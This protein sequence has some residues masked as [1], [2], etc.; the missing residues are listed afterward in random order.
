MDER[1]PGIPTYGWTEAGGIVILKGKAAPGRS[2]IKKVTAE[3]W[4][5]WYPV[6]PGEYVLADNKKSKKERGFFEQP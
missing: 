1:P 3:G 5:A 2:P 6:H 4:D